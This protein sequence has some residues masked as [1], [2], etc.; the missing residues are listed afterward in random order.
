MNRMDKQEIID[1]LYSFNTH[2]DITIEE[3][4]DDLAIPSAE[5]KTGHWIRGGYDEYYYVC[6]QCD[7]VA[8]EYYQ[9]PTYH[10]CPNCGAKMIEPQERSE[11]VT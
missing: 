10:F 9:I 3:M 8:S 7:Y 11:N 5:P 2:A 1:Y 6:D 4:A